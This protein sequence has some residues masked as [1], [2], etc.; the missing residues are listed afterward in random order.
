MTARIRHMQELRATKKRNGRRNKILKEMIDRRYK[1]LNRLRRTD[2]KCYEWIL[3]KLDLQF[4][5]PPMELFQIT[6]KDS[7]RRL[8]NIHCDNIKNTRLDVYRKQLEAEQ[9]PF[10]GEKLKNMEFLR[11]E[12]LDLGIEVTVTE[13]DIANVRKTYEEMKAKAAENATDEDGDGDSTRKW[14]SY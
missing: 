1:Y 13:D 4:K 3:E 14:K 5:P 2:Y 6:R 9:L 10:L 8:T 11:A 7:L 12:Q